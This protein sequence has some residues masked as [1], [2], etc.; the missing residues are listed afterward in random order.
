MTSR[1]S[2]AELKEAFERVA[3]ATRCTRLDE[4][5]L[6][7]S[8]PLPYGDGDHPQVLV[9]LSSGGVR[10]ED[11]GNA[12]DRLRGLGLDLDGSTLADQVIDIVQE[13]GLELDRDAITL[14]I[15]DEESL[16]AQLARLV[17]C[18]L[19]VDALRHSGRSDVE[20]FAERVVAWLSGNDVVPF[21]E[22]RSSIRIEGRE[23]R[24]A[25]RLA[26]S[27]EEYEAPEFTYLQTVI[28]RPALYRAHFVLSDLDQPAWRKMAV[29]APQGVKRLRSLLPRLEGV[30]AVASWEA[31]DA[32]AAWL[33]ADD[34]TR[35]QA[36]A[37]LLPE[38]P[39]F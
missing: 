34:E 36:G 19:Q 16:D 30:A 11:F 37:S 21:V 12:L 35:R 25:A 9:H 18:L 1:P 39:L 20:T 14:R 31:Q 2:C 13:H 28:N 29:I 24:I 22:P 33:Q 8:L 5:L 6:L 3:A 7:L 17:A 10:V 32:L 27:V 38:R 23:Y 15:D 4:D 26:R